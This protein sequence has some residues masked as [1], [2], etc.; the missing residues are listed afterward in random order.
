[1]KYK[2]SVSEDLYSFPERGEDQHN[3]CLDL[4]DKA[5]ELI[6]RVRSL[7][8]SARKIAARGVNTLQVV[9]NFEIGR[10]I[11]ENEQKGEKRAQYGKQVIGELSE[12]LS[13]EFGRG[14][15]KSNL[16]YMCHVTSKM[17]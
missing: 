1:M 7:I 11:V 14:F 12:D 17:A 5:N 3:R 10:M 4:S 15:S 13:E 6:Q 16:E 2:P 8:L 9:T